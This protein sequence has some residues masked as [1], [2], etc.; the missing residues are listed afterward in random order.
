M[1]SLL[2]IKKA[3]LLRI[4]SL[5]KKMIGFTMALFPKLKRIGKNRH[6]H[7]EFYAI[8]KRWYKNKYFRLCRFV[9]S[10]KPLT[11]KKRRVKNVA[12]KNI[13]FSQ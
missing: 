7:Q 11:N 1:L 3:I 13:R 8:Q 10:L 12:Y 2:N 5:F 4:G 9:F 6:N